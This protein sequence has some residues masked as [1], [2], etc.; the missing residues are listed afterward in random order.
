MSEAK[1]SEATKSTEQATSEVTSVAD[2]SSEEIQAE[3]ERVDKE[4]ARA[5]LPPDPT[6]SSEGRVPRAHTGET[7]AREAQAARR[8]LLRQY[9]SL[10]NDER[11]TDEHRASRAW[12]AYD[13]S[14]PLIEEKA[15]SAREKLL[16]SADEYEM[17]SIP[18]PGGQ[19]LR[20][21]SVELLS[22]TQGERSRIV[23]RLSYQNPTVERMRAAGKNVPKGSEDRPANI[24]REEFSR[25]L[26]IGGP[27]GGAICRAVVGLAQDRGMNVDDIVDDRRRD[28]Q[29]DY[30]RKAEDARIQARSIYS[31]VPLP[32]TGRP[33]GAKSPQEARAGKR[34]TAFG[35]PRKASSSA[36]PTFQKK[37]RKPPWK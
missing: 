15:K 12:Q 30:L 36:G 18:F 33:G 26:D 25:G 2:M 32:S 5:S 3:I 22:L 17:S 20:T 34:R 13:E 28:W 19:S 11:Y 6:L 29:R 9:E 14:K 24:L 4:L 7:L 8:D 37:N 27:Q 31:R 16:K 23:E 1:P 21:D 10:D 35:M